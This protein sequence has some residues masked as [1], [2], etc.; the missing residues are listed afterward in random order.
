M[1]HSMEVNSP[2]TLPQIL[3]CIGTQP[4]NGVIVDRTQT[5]PG[6]TL[7]CGQTHSLVVHIEDLQELEKRNVLPRQISEVLVERGIILGR[8][9]IS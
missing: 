3:D 9:S 5:P 4:I 8:T 6:I 7:L 2:A 1:E